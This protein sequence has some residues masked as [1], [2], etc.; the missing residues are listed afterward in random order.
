M[1]SCRVS[2]EEFR[3]LRQVCGDLGFASFSHLIR[4]AVQELLLNRSGRGSTAVSYA[5]EQLSTRVDAL[6]ADLWKKKA[7]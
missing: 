7:Q 3:T 6:E 4:T 2:D 5:V 1:I